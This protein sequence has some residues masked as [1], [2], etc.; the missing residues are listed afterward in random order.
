MTLS[1][2][3]LQ[4]PISFCLP[5]VC[6]THEQFDDLVIGLNENTDKLINTAKQF[7]NL[8][9]LYSMV[10]EKTNTTSLIK[11]V[12]NLF[13]SDTEITFQNFLPN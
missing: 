7:I 12:T 13:Y 1:K 5:K 9:D 4:V 3:P 6:N 10:P 11:L 8:G 2:F